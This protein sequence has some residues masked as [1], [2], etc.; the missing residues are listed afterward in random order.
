MVARSAR[1]DELKAFRSSLPDTSGF[2][3]LKTAGGGTHLVQFSDWPI[4]GGCAARW[5]KLF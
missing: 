4:D 3:N 5:K 1:V 2:V